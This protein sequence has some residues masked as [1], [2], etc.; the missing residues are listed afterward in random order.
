MSSEYAISD[1]QSAG[2]SALFYAVKEGHLTITKKLI[3]AG[4][5]IFLKDNVM[6][7]VYM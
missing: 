6:L 3:E 2:W 4:A 7:N 5:D 1:P